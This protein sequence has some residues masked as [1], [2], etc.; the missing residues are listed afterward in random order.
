MAVGKNRKDLTRVSGGELFPT[1]LLVR[2]DQLGRVGPMKAMGS[3]GSGFGGVVSAVPSLQH[4]LYS[5]GD[6]RLSR[7]DRSA[8]T[9]A[10]CGLSLFFGWGIT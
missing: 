2:I 7:A 1:F 4:L 5:F 6:L 3:S 8:A 9:F 10:P